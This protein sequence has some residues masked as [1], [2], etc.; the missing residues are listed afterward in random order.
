MTEFEVE[1]LVL[2]VEAAQILGVTT[3]TLARYAAL[4]LLTERRTMGRHHR[5]LRSELDWD[6]IRELDDKRRGGR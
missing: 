4:G 6:R 1:D 3:R 5:Y 2:P